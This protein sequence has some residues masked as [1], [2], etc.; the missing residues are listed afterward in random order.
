MLSHRS[1]KQEIAKGAIVIEHLNIDCIQPASLDI[2]LDN[3]L[4]VFKTWR[5][6]FYVDVSN[7]AWL[8]L[9]SL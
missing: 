7:R 2:D 6:P 1:I 9:P 3:K 5:Y 4:L 8:I